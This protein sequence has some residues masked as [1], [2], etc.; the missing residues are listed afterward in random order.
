MKSLLEIIYA[1][2]EKLNIE[3]DDQL[4]KELDISSSNL[5]NRK[6]INSIP[7]KQIINLCEKNKLSADEI[8]FG[9]A[10]FFK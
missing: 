9:K 8:F 10:S 6:N 5:A 2:K 1:L 7:F 3:Y 4:A